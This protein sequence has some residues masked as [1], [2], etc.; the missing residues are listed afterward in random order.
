MCHGLNRGELRL[1]RWHCCP[2]QQDDIRSSARA[3]WTAIRST[4]DPVSLTLAD[5]FRVPIC[6]VWCRCIR[7]STRTCM[8]TRCL[9]AFA[10]VGTSRV[11]CGIVPLATFNSTFKGSQSS[12]IRTLHTTTFQA[13]LLFVPRC[14]KRV[15]CRRAC[16]QR[17]T[18]S[19]RAK[20]SPFRP[21][22]STSEPQ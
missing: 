14:L 7:T 22:P 18:R 9:T 6:G 21:P 20:R 3:D 16:D 8:R 4:H 2:S 11:G 15:L 5:D 10:A 19:I 12:I 13:A 1:Y 17:D